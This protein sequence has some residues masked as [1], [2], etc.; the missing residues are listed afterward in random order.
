[1][2][3]Y[4]L[5]IGILCV[6]LHSNTKRQTMN[7][8][9][10][11]CNELKAVRKRIAEENDIPL[12]IKECSYKGQCSGTCP[13]CESEVRYLEHALAERMRMGK[14]A[15]IAGLALGLSAVNNAN[16]QVVKSADPPDTSEVKEPRLEGEVMAN[17]NIF[18]VPEI[19]AEFPGG[20]A[21]LNRFIEENLQYP[22]IAA[23]TGIGGTVVVEFVID[24][25]GDI[26]N[27]RI[28][29]EI[30]GGCG[31]EAVRIVKLMPK[32]IP[33][34]VNN[35]P[36]N[37]SYLLPIFFDISKHGIPMLE[38]KVPLPP[39]DT[40]VIKIKP[41][42]LPD[43]CEIYKKDEKNQG[44]LRGDVRVIKSSTIKTRK[45]DTIPEESSS[46]AIIEEQ[47]DDEIINMLVGAV[48]THKGYSSEATDDNLWIRF[49][50]DNGT[51][52][53]QA[54]P[55]DKKQLYEEN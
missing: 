24:T 45:G 51:P 46:S 18:P 5:Q 52:A 39:D 53:N 28:V 27:I 40:T 14:V 38:G 15:T 49:R 37:S 54:N 7:P 29:R 30:G 11:I 31:K 36:V 2:R 19:E 12:E 26:S 42:P 17:D 23:E 34:K 55:D 21:A 16:A 43:S 47:K 48:N 13:K 4:F 35:R 22:S 3:K 20:E 1:M 41:D 50:D 8:G 10:N 6:F 32:W 33:G 44:T 25:N 9:K